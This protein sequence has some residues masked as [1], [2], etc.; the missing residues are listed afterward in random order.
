MKR[1]EEETPEPR[2]HSPLRKSQTLPPAAIELNGGLDL[3]DEKQI[4]E[5]FALLE[6]QAGEKGFPRALIEYLKNNIIAMDF[7]ISEMG[8]VRQ[9]NEK[10]KAE[11]QNAQ[12]A[13]KVTEQQK[14]VGINS[15]NQENL[16]LKEQIAVLL[17]RN[18][19]LANAYKDIQTEYYKFFVD[20]WKIIDF[21]R[22]IK[23]KEI[24]DQTT[25]SLTKKSNELTEA[26][27]KVSELT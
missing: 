15:V 5:V 19:E 25:M 27:L 2:P 23:L 21:L 3:T 7:K 1:L 9:E 18:Q 26:H 8:S 14:I 12:E 16:K 24:T 6:S 11:I 10:L 22:N 13:R 20:R 4:P 17:S